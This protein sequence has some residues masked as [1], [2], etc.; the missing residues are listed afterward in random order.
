MKQVYYLDHGY[1]FFRWEMQPVLDLLTANGVSVNIKHMPD[2]MNG[3]YNQVVLTNI[4]AADIWDEMHKNGNKIVHV[5][6][7][8]DACMSSRWANKLADTFC[9]ASTI[10][11]A[12]L[13]N[14]LGRDRVVL[15]GMPYLD[16]YEFLK[17]KPSKEA[18]LLGIQAPFA[19]HGYE[20][21][22]TAEFLDDF[23][24]NHPRKQGWK[25]LR[26][27]FHQNHSH[28]WS[29]SH[30]PVQDGQLPT[31]TDPVEKTPE[32]LYNSRGLYTSY[33]SFM[34]MEACLLDKPIIIYHDNPE[35]RS[36]IEGLI[37]DPGWWSAYPWHELEKEEKRKELKEAFAI[38]LDGN[39]AQRVADEVLKLV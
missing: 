12:A 39:S 10:E 7:S 6:R 34:L 27:R 2:E 38:N 16:I 25:D 5:S 31:F 11:E 35:W 3:I 14:L 4:P 8:K 13:V 23:Y 20:F 32:I 22:N 21:E 26:F 15:T 30:I 33:F 24:V 19:A 1:D 29:D 18:Y 17:K 37:N 9:A 36:K 28:Y